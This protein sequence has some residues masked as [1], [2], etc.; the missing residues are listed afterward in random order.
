MV[1]TNIKTYPSYLIKYKL[2]WTTRNRKKIREEQ[3]QKMLQKMFLKYKRE[4]AYRSISS[5]GW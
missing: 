1:Y 5:A 2:N 4:N 3:Q